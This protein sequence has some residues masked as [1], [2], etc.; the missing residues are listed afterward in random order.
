MALSL[1]EGPFT[2]DVQLVFG[3]D[4]G[5]VGTLGLCCWVSVGLLLS[6]SVEDVL[7]IEG[8]PVW[9]LCI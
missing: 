9:S 7:E 3:L 8:E 6:G 1:G 5:L 2:Y 4:D